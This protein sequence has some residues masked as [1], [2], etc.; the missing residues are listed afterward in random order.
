MLLVISIVTALANPAARTGGSNPNI[1]A[2][3]VAF[4][5]VAPHPNTPT[6]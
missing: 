3:A 6:T 1:L 2:V 5:T 4:S